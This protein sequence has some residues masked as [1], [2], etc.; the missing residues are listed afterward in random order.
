MLYYA[1]DGLVMSK[2]LRRNSNSVLKRIGLFVLKI[3]VFLI[4]PVTILVF[5]FQLKNITVT[6][7]SRYDS[8]QIIERLIESKADNNTLVFF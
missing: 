4:L 6:G 2:K 8:G 1:K 5:T 3:T 7:S